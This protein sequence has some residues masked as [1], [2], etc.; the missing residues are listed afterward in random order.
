MNEWMYT[1]KKTPNW[2]GCPER[3]GQAIK[4]RSV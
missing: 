3:H 4:Y 2:N 1:E